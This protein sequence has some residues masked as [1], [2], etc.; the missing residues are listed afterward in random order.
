MDLYRNRREKYTVKP[1]DYTNAQMLA[2]QSA[3]LYPRIRL[4]AEGVTSGIRPGDKVPVYFTKDQKQN[5][6]KIGTDSLY[7][8]G[9]TYFV[10]VQNGEKRK[11]GDSDWLYE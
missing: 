8:E 4:E 7:N 6:L 9:D 3:E 1:F 10:Y 5:V 2:I 11:T